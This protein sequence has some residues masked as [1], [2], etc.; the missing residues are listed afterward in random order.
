[1]LEISETGTPVLF[2]DGNAMQAKRTHFGPELAGEDILTIDRI[3]ARR[4]PVLRKAVHRFAQQI[5]LRTQAKI[6]A[7][8]GIRDHATPP[9]AIREFTTKDSISSR[10]GCQRL[11]RDRSESCIFPGLCDQLIDHA[12]GRRAGEEEALHLIASRK[13]QQY[14]LVLGLDT[15]DQHRQA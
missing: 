14:A 9:L 4:N 6:K 3:G 1:M 15:L 2:F 13:A 5:D 12:G 11:A 7:S 10:S 8:P